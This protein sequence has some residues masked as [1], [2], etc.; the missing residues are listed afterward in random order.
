MKVVFNFIK[1]IIITV[2]AL[3]AIITTI[4]LISYNE[5]SVSE[6]GDYSVFIV[7]NER[8]EPEFYEDDIVIIKKIAEN[9][10]NVGDYA[11]FYL[12]NPTDEVFI[13]YGKITKI[14]TADHAEDSYYFG[15]DIIPYSKMIGLANGAIVYHKWGKVLEILESKWGFMFL[16]ILPTLFAIVYEVFA[17]IDEAREVKKEIEKEEKEKDE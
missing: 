17:I 1:G 14:T 16:V 7:D 8:L 9:K 11:F 10:Y 5:Y 13:N 2:W 15:N 12:E 3:F 6:I 4:C